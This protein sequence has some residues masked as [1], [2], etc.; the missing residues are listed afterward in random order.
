M[1]HA[2][3]IVGPARAIAM[4]AALVAV[5][6]GSAAGQAPLDI[7]PT[8]GLRAKG[9][10]PRRPDGPADAT[11]E[12]ATR[13]ELVRKWDLD[14]N[15]TID[16]SEANIART[17]IRRERRELELTPGI[18]PITGRLR[19]ASPDAATDEPAND[20]VVTPELPPAPRKR[21]DDGPALPG[22]RV[23]A[24]TPA[25]P[26][27]TIPTVR[28]PVVGPTTPSS[29]EPKAR[30]RSAAREPTDRGERVGS[31]TGGVRAG[32]PAARQGYG[33]LVPRGDLNAGRRPLELP[34]TP[35]PRGGLLPSLQ[36]P[37]IPGRVAPAVPQ[38]PA[39]PAVRPRITAEDIGG[40]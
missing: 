22:T 38:P 33:S 17:R 1:H 21:R 4:G 24:L 37:A 5:I 13:E 25:V 16:P 2:R 34:R 20:T 10:V 26:S 15:G 6:A 18:D 11:P 19:D 29:I 8:G 23:P 12:G 9:L 7:D 30:P 32:A 40:Y 36:R 35:L 14:G 28:S 39:P 27:P 31:V 3:S